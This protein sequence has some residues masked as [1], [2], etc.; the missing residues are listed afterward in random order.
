[1]KH[2]LKRTLVILLLT[3]ISINTYADYRLG[4][5]YKIVD[6]PLPV[7]KDGTVEV[8]E[9]FWYGCGACYSFEPA[10]N[11]WAAKQNKDVKLIKLPITWGG[12]HQL[13]ASLYYT[14]EALKLDKSTHAA[15][16]VSIHKEGNFLSSPA[17]IQ[18]FLEKFGVAPEVSMQYLNSFA[19][20]QRVNRGV[21]YAKQLKLSSVPMII[22]DGKYIIESK[23]SFKEMLKV[24]DHVI[25]IQKPNT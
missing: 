9:S 8:I 13:H 7:K 2:S 11:S 17:S 1:M 4:V 16:F 19:V 10:I 3:T 14:I 18:N 25:E 12:I 21:K 6:N 23:G 15:V 5:D 22:V 24:V 20:K